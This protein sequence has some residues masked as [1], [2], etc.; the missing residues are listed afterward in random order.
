VFFATRQLNSASE[1]DVIGRD[2]KRTTEPEILEPGRRQRDGFE[3][4]ARSRFPHL[5]GLR[6][7]SALNLRL[8]SKAVV[9]IKG[10][11]NCLQTFGILGTLD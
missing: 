3:G 1:Q 10:T 11:L 2:R 7:Y 9:L 4:L 6:S 8:R 5:D